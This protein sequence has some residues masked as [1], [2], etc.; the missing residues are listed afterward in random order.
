MK[1]LKKTN[2]LFLMI[3]IF[4]FTLSLSA[5]TKLVEIE[6]FIPEELKYA[7]FKIDT[8]QNIKIEVRGMNPDY[9]RGDV[10][11]SNA[12]IL[13]S[14]TREVVWYLQKSEE[15]KDSGDLAEFED[16]IDLQP[17]M[18]EVYFST[19]MFDPELD[20]RRYGNNYVYKHRNKGFFSWFFTELC[21]NDYYVRNKLDWDMFDEFYIKVSGNG[22]SLSADD[23]ESLVRNEKDKDLLKLVQI[24]N[25][26]FQQYFLK[27]DKTVTCN[28]YAIGEADHDG[29]YDFGR[30][31][32]NDT[33]EKIW[34]L[35]YRHSEH[36]GGAYK[37]RLANECLK[38]EPGEYTI[39]YVTDDSHAFHRWNIH[40]PYDPQ[41]WGITISMDNAA[42]K[43]FVKLTEM[44]EIAAKNRIIDITEMRDNDYISK[45]FTLKK[46]LNLHLYAIG[47]GS[48]GDMYDFA[49]IV[50]AKTREEVWRMKY[51]D[52]K[53][54]GGAD[55]NRMVD[56]IVRFEPGNY[57]VYYL[58]DD[59]HS[60][61][62]WNSTP[63]FDQKHWGITISVNDDNYNQGDVAEYSP[64]EDKNI[65]IRMTR[66][67][68]YEKKHQSFELKQDGKIHIYA[69]GE[70][71][72]GDMYDYAWIENANTGN[73]VWEMTYRKTERAGGA[74]KNR[75]FD[76]TIYLD[77]GEYDVYYRTDDSHSFEEWNDSP[78]YD[79]ESWGITIYYSNNY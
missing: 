6:N 54:A 46:P 37:N 38:L 68:D 32:K 35:D 11:M 12:W 77:K 73:V 69:I 47:E 44:E 41:N 34:E 45:G 49:R 7:G 1:P 31:I 17:G 59:S 29:D 40:P 61:K 75:L 79:P 42:D 65:L 60:Y 18:Y 5:Q 67:G 19:F 21:D 56:E 26:F 78:P 2:S 71:T 62:D 16:I 23:I 28:I 64:E 33:R 24:K 63:P 30:I 25:D 72:H 70:G 36:A 58:T 51:Y 52:T 55:K 22:Q 3:F 27:V 9:F 14:G 4:S 10:T 57:I 39:L 8:P 15:S 53:S 48:G 50:N 66:I 74:R 43:Q 13:D 20:H 76:D